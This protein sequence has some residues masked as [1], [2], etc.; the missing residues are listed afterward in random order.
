MNK[1]NNT[2]NNSIQE[3]SVVKERTLMQAFYRL[4]D[5]CKRLHET[6]NLVR[7]L[8]QK[9]NRT[10]ECSEVTNEKAIISGDD[11]MN[12]VDLFNLIA[13][14]IENEIRTIEDNT[15]KSIDMID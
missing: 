9:L 14:K 15:H 4:E 2:M 7:I 3:T 10:Q 8:N 13:D 12:I 1:M 5:K 6:T 11:I